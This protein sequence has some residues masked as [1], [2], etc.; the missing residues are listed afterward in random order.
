MHDQPMRA[1]RAYLL[2][3]STRQVTA[4]V[5][6]LRHRVDIHTY[7]NVSSPELGL[8]DIGVVEIEANRPLYFDAYR[9]NRA[10]GSFILVDPLHNG[11]VAAGMILATVDREDG[12]GVVTSAE[13]SLRYGH[14]AAVVWISDSPDLA[15]EIERALFDMHCLVGVTERPEVASA[16]AA[17]GLIAICAGS[18]EAKFRLRSE[19]AN[20][21]FVDL[22]EL[23]HCSVESAVEWLRQAGILELN[24]RFSSGEGI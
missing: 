17:A 16:L 7:E 3:H 6:S 23:A 22:D 19:T 20:D 9:D 13:R 5:T 4:R 24:E 12:S 10:T 11:T 1:G 21:R 18:Q 15:Q 8:N 14:H 2:K